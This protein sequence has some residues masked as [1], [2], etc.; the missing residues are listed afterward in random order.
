MTSIASDGE[1]VLA[2]PSLVN[3]FPARVTGSDGSLW[4]QVRAVLCP[5]MLVIYAERNEPENGGKYVQ[6][7]AAIALASAQARS[8]SWLASTADGVAYEIVTDRGCGCASL[9][10]AMPSVPPVQLD[11]WPA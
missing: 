8:G 11:R 7:D 9:L 3:L 6:T 2:G 5:D 1:T 4:E 10:R